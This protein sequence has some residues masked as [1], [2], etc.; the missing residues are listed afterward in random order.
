VGLLLAVLLAATVAPE[1]APEPERPTCAVA[2]HPAR[3]GACVAR[4]DADAT[5]KLYFRDGRSA[6]WYFVEATGEKGCAWGVIPAPGHSV[7]RVVYY[8]ELPTRDGPQR[9]LDRSIRVA[10]TLDQCGGDR[11]AG[12]SI[13]EPASVGAMPGAPLTPAGFGP[14]ATGGGA[15][16]WVLGS[17]VA[18]AGAGAAVAL[19]SGRGDDSS[20]A[21]RQPAASPTGVGPVTPTPTP[22]ATPRPTPEPPR[23]PTATPT[24][25][26]PP[27]PPPPSTPTARP[28][29][30]P[31]A[32]PR[33]APTATPR[34]QPTSTPAPTVTPT[35]KPPKKN[36]ADQD[37]VVVD[38]QSDL[39]AP[40]ARGQIVVDDPVSPATAGGVMIAGPG[41]AAGQLRLPPAG[42]RRLALTVSGA[43]GPGQWRLRLGGRNVLAGSLRVLAG[44][45][46][47]AGGDTVIVNVRGPTPAAAVVVFRG[48]QPPD[49]ITPRNPAP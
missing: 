45:A 24:A 17:A 7:R 46:S 42:E 19:R 16:A 38:W 18:A 26:P 35:P 21:P 29:A 4:A 34:P 5:G 8:V 32:T 25:E 27:P 10:R 44:D 13:A 28:T 39:R 20:A 31:R 33:P 15:P 23:R 22:T 43:A 6:H 3:L 9:S 36:S 41:V 37:P 1:S 49:A 14:D 48:A 30:T 11:V 40:E 47:L 2:G 12:T